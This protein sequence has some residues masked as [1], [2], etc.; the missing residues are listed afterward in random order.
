MLYIAVE[1]CFANNFKLAADFLAD[2]AQTA[3]ANALVL[4]EQATAAYM[5]TDFKSALI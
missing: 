4:H 3:G 2:A 1:Y 5:E